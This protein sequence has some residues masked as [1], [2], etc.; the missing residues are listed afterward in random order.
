MKAL[1]IIMS[2]IMAALAIFQTIMLILNPAEVI[3]WWLISMCFFA[4][5]VLNIVFMWDDLWN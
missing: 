2:T 3:I 4:T 1:I 5:F